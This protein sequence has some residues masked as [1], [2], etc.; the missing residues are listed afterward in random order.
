[1]NKD[2]AT[3][4]GKIKINSIEWYVPHYTPSIPQ[5]AI[6]SKQII[7]KLTT[8]LQYVERS[9]FMKEV[10]I[11]NFCTFELGT[12]E[13]VNIPIWI[14]V[15]FQQTDRQNSQHTNNDTFYRPPVTFAQCITGTENYPD[16]A[17]LLNYL[18]DV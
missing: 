5:H 2:K 11:Q 12:Q 16:S 6:I 18:D 10:K 14:I 8:E 17:T 9:V 1:M 7:S 13:G 3:Y 4:T 15:D